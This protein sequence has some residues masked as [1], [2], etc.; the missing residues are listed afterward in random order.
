MRQYPIRMS[1]TPPRPGGVL[2]RGYPAYAED[3]DHVYGTLLGISEADRRALAEQ[4]VI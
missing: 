2:N 3:N 1:E 4:D